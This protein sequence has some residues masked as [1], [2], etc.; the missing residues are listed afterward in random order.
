MIEPVSETELYI[1][2]ATLHKFELWNQ[3]VLITNINGCTVNIQ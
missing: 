2:L 1:I 3:T